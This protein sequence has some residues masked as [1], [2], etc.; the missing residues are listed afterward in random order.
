MGPARSPRSWAFRPSRAPA[1]AS[2]GIADP[3]DQA[4]MTRARIPRPAV[5]DGSSPARARAT[6]RRLARSTKKNVRALLVS[7]PSTVAVVFCSILVAL[8]W[9]AKALSGSN[10]ATTPSHVSPDREAVIAGPASAT[11]R[12]SVVGGRSA[13]SHLRTESKRRDP[14]H[15][16]VG[17]TTAM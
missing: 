13:T 5:F 4:S 2:S 1:T 16:I 12:S 8:L 6:S 14:S 15:I 10:T 17:A 11:W 3:S 9:N 7:P